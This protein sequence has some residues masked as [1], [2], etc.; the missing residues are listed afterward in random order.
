MAVIWQA[1]N[2]KDL[3]LHVAYL[4]DTEFVCVCVCVEHLFEVYRT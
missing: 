1:N 3:N 2:S 4:I